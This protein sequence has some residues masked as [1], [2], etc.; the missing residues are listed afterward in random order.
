LKNNYRTVEKI[1]PIQFEAIMT[2]LFNKG[3]VIAGVV[4]RNNGEI[5]YI[6]SNWSVEPSDLAQCIKGWQARSQF[7]NLQ[8]IKYSLLMNT[9]EYFSG[10]NYK[11][12]TW[13]FG[14]ASPGDEKYYVIGYAPAGA[15]GTNAYVDVVRAANQMKEGGAYAAEAQFG[16]YQDKPAAGGAGGGG[17]DPALKQE[18]DGFLQW[19][20]D[21]NGLAGYIDYYLQQNDPNVIPKLAKAYNDF[22]RVFGF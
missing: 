10:I 12:K 3:I 8:S 11:D 9:P 1:M 14:A 6:S 4:C 18:V 21:P 7:V 22:R 17:I 13:L 5:V 19:I 15:N 2:D 20:K 16:K